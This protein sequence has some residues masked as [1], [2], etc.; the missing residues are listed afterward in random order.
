MAKIVLRT[1]SNEIKDIHVIFLH[2]LGGD[3][4]GTWLKKG[5]KDEAWP[6]WLA[7]DNFDLNIWTVEYDASKLKSDS[8]GMGIPDLAVNIF[9]HILKVPELAEGE[10]IFVCHSLGGLITKQILRIAND[11]TNRVEVQQFLGRVSGV[12]FL[13]TPH[14][15]ADIANHSDNI[16][17]K[18]L[19]RCLTFQQPSIVTASLS[20]ND[21][22]LR[23]LNTW[24]RDWC[25]HKEIRHLV[26]TETEKMYGI[27]TIVKPDSAD[28]GITGV[29]PIPI[30]VSHENIC[31]PNDKNDEIYT[32][33]KGFLSQKKREFHDLWI[34]SRFYNDTNSWEGYNNWAH[35]PHGTS[36]EYFV[37]E[38]IRL[39]DSS[40]SNNEG[41][42]GLDGL[43][44][45]R[46]KLLER[47]ASI[48]LVGLSG[49]GKTR[50][51]QALFDERIGEN[52]L[53][54]KAVF[55][56]D[57]ANSPKPTP[58]AL[59]EKIAGEGRKAILIIDNCPPDLHRSLI[60]LCCTETSNTNL[61]TVEYD[62]RE[63]Q[64]EQTEVFSLEPSS[65]EL[66]EKILDARYQHL[67]QQNSRTISKFSCGNSRI[68]LALAETIGKD[69][70]ISSLRDEE[71]FKRLF[72]QR[73]ANEKSLETAAQYL[74]LV[75][76]FQINSENT[77]SDDITFLSNLS[78]IPPRDIYESAKE[79]KRRNLVQQRSKW[80]AVLPHPITN[81]LAKYA[82]ENIST[83]VISDNFN[84]STDERLLKSFSRRLGYLPK[85]EEAKIIV[86]AWLNDNGL[87][88]KLYAEGK[89]ELAWV[90]LTNIAPISTKEVL[91]HIETLAKQSEFCTR[92]NKQ[93]TE[94]TRLIR[95]I[96][97]DEQ[98]FDICAKLLCQ[99]TLSEDKT[100]NNNS[101]KDI[102][103]SLFQLYLSGTHATKE[104]RLD[105][106]KNLISTA[107]EHSVEL[108]FELLDASLEAWHFSSSHS[109]DFGA[110]PRDFGYRPKT[111][112]D[113]TDWYKLFIEYITKLIAGDSQIS[114]SAKKVLSKNLRSLWRVS[115]LRGAIEKVCIEISK[116]GMWSDGF[117][118][119]HSILKYDCSSS[120]EDEIQR[121]KSISE[122]LSPSSLLDDIDMYVLAKPWRLHALDEVDNNGKVIECGYEKGQKY[123]IE[124][125]TQLANR[126]PKELEDI[127]YKLLSYSEMSSNLFAF[128][129]GYAEGVKNNSEVLTRV[130][131]ALENISEKERNLDFL[132][133]QIYYLSKH[134][135]ALTNHFL[136]SLLIHPTL[137]KHFIRVQLSYQIDKEAI[138]RIIQALQENTCL[139]SEY[140]DLAARG[141][142]EPIPDEKL[143]E[144]LGLIWHKEGGQEVAINILS[145]R[146]H[147]LKQN[148]HYVISELLKEKSAS[149][150]ASFDY[151]EER[152]PSGGSD[153][154]LS[155]IANVCFSSGTNDEYALTVLKAIKAKISNYIIGRSDFPEFMST[156]I[157]L[158]PIL[159]L[160]VFI[161]KNKEVEP[162]V[163]NVIKGRLDKKASPF[164]KV[165]IKST[166]DWCKYNGR[167]SYPAL[168]S[169]ITPYQSN[170]K[171]VEWTQLAVEL[172]QACPEPDVVLDKYLYSFSPNGWTG[173]RAKILESRLPLFQPLIDST[174]ED[175]SK[176]GIVKKAQWETYIASE[177]DREVERDSESNERFEW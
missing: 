68:A 164:S 18:I 76:S 87:L 101:I 14:L 146:F 97:Y 134:N 165:D 62:L 11:Q 174:N 19:L 108:A 39:L 129:K 117:V 3:A 54:H 7:E 86:N 47:K 84:E 49:V 61:L 70:N 80:M 82:L 170:G 116:S 158:H 103:K 10:I 96:A 50:F 152:E 32:H 104:Q 57:M 172:L 17:A 105:V 53:P 107:T 102:L 94:I 114:S 60:T 74:S 89:N 15:G 28:P 121:L 122:L 140:H 113:I 22:N 1:G 73:H 59:A 175:I 83:G 12:A 24:Y 48:R 79:L 139:I 16:F 44:L 31:K 142:L 81:R 135:I 161:G 98:Y 137:K 154:S 93:F 36:G 130:I 88:H 168:A 143:C 25:Q 100:E 106:I 92:K 144:I 65:I 169:I 63:D 126:P 66:I 136:D 131:T 55:Y 72:Y 38:Q 69:E 2:G 171:T 6:I 138:A 124:L 95:S 141:R 56:T 123:S 45:I 149:L 9:E 75:Y 132:C 157:Q 27:V 162:L 111:N 173:S 21:P 78:E 67:G 115:S 51:V 151:S 13:G 58:Q 120:N 20:R 77:Y 128:G 40:S 150:L 33:I 42:K 41:L 177:Y 155:Q 156:V 166:L 153:Y 26:L 91:L 163:I 159:A 167:N 52:P 30:S 109:F 23:E 4:N 176:W 112:Q 46:N 133:G 43:N 148:Q 118:A 145:S 85:C 34:K 99:F 110:N 127:L 35:C 147:R 64:P 125:G 8:S 29:R 119:I 71:L 160:E 90:L 37:D 5:S